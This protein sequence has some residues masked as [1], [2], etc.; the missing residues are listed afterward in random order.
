MLLCAILLFSI[1]NVSVV[2]ADYTT[3]SLSTELI[4]Y[5]GFTTANINTWISLCS[6]NNFSEFTLRL[7]AYSEFSSETLSAT[8]KS[9]SLQIIAAA[10]AVGINVNIDIHTWY[11][12][13]DT[14]FDDGASSETVNRAHHLAYIADVIENLDVPGVASFMVLNEPQAQT[15]STSENNFILSCI[16]TAQALTDLPISVRFMAGYSPSTGHYNSAIDTASDFLCRNTY[17]DPR[18]PSVAKYGTTE[19]K[20]NTLIALA[21][22]SGKEL[23]ITEFGLPYSSGNEAQRAYVE[24]WVTYAQTKEIDRIFCWASKPTGSEGYNIFN[25]WTPRPA[26]YELANAASAPEPETVYLTVES[27]GNGSTSPL[28]GVHAYTENEAVTITLIPDAG[29]IARLEVDGVNVTLTDLSYDLVLAE[30]TT[31]TPTFEPPPPAYYYLDL[32]VASGLLCSINDVYYDNATDIEYLIDTEITLEIATVTGYE[33]LAVEVDG[34]NSTDTTFNVTMDQNHTVITYA[35]ILGHTIILPAS[36]QH[37]NSPMELNIVAGESVTYA[38]YNYNLSSWV[39]AL[40][41]YS[42]PVSLLLP[43]GYSR[44]TTYGAVAYAVYF[45]IDSPTPSPTPTATPTATPAPTASAAPTIAPEQQAIISNPDGI[46]S[47]GV[48]FNIYTTT[49]LAFQ[50]E[51]VNKTVAFQVLNGTWNGTGGRLGITHKYGQLYFYSHDAASIQIEQSYEHKLRIYY[52]GFILHTLTPGYSFYGEIPANTTCFIIWSWNEPLIIEE[53]WSLIMG[54]FG[55]ILFVS[56]LIMMAWS[57]KTYPIFSFKR[58]TVW[59]QSIVLYA[60]VAL[61][62]GAGLIMV[63]LMG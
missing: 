7:P 13:W 49:G 19:A 14:Y 5:S 17:W 23:W 1:C 20:M 4:D 29:Y 24:G 47:E 18:N 37:Y 48:G 3:T 62:I 38:I 11:T 32:S 60:L 12:T 41:P 61:I 51:V 44:I 53:N 56:G 40:T 55:L 45:W 27:A 59:D 8:Y 42:A 36:G 54:L 39:V 63:W 34:V 28:A 10:Y 16:S 26:W 50:H 52:E 22:S 6:A 25:G 2:H 30:N 15:A 31:I 9:K 46:R 33:F 58:E 43:V 35:D 21:A 57:F